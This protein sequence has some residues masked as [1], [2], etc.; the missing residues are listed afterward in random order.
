MSSAAAERLVTTDNV[1]AIMGAD[2]SGVT[3]GI[4]NN[5]ETPLFT[6]AHQGIWLDTDVYLLKPI[7]SGEYLLAAEPGISPRPGLGPRALAVRQRGRRSGTINN[8]V[9]RLPVD[10][11]LLPPLLM[12]FDQ[13]NV[14]RW[15]PLR[16]RI[17][18]R[19]RLMTTG[20]S[21]LSR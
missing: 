1:A 7:I 9:L 14:P 13:D 8:A 3:I 5:A 15:M 21:D 16:D 20:R 17:K 19:W 11:P 4:V 10:S 2:C 18:A 6:E 12:L